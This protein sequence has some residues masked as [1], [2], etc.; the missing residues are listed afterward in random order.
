MVEGSSLRGSA[1]VVVSLERLVPGDVVN[2][3]AAVL[4]SAS[5]SPVGLR[6]AG[7]L[8]TRGG[9]D[10]VGPQAPGHVYRGSLRTCGLSP[11]SNNWLAA[12][13]IGPCDIVL[14]LWPRY[15]DSFQTT[16][17]ARSH[18]VESVRYTP[19]SYC[20]E[21]HKER[22][23]STR[24]RR[25]RSRRWSPPPRARAVVRAACSHCE[26]ER[27]LARSSTDPAMN[28]RES[29]GRLARPDRWRS[30][31]ASRGLRG[32]ALGVRSRCTS[33]DARTA[34]EDVDVEAGTTTSRS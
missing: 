32:L 33:L 3:V 17:Q 9:G 7:A 18:G 10:R 12:V 23:T 26:S 15:D 5:R 20:S 25:V 22:A 16:L 2:P 14:H 24:F 27:A 4:F 11:A 21:V 29:G 1:A 8:T 31:A 13:G 19:T 34:G 30:Y 6:Q 28:R